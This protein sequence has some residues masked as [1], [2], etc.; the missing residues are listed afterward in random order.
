MI[1]LPCEEQRG[2]GGRGGGGC[3][4]SRHLQGDVQARKGGGVS[5]ENEEG[6]CRWG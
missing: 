6:V 2:W 1:Q 4:A 5:S 3:A